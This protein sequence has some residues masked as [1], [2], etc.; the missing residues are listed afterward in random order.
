MFVARIL[1]C[2]RFCNDVS[3]CG[4][5]KHFNCYADAAKRCII[6]VKVYVF[7]N[8]TLMPNKPSFCFQS[9]VKDRA[10]FIFFRFSSQIAYK[11]VTMVTAC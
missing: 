7:V 4:I 10:S 9:N 3:A 11:C 6:L 5:L 2:T 8:D 1:S